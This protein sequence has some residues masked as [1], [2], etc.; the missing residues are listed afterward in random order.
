MHNFVYLAQLRSQE[1]SCELNFG[2]GGGFPPPPPLGCASELHTHGLLTVTFLLD[3][4]QQRT[5]RNEHLWSVRYSV[6][7]ARHRTTMEPNLRG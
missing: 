2:G 6:I 1:F 3:D 4:R 7:L 5:K